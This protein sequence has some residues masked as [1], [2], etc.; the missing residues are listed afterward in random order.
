MDASNQSRLTSCLPNMNVY[1]QVVKKLSLKL[2][3][4]LNNSWNQE[5][6]MHKNVKGG[7]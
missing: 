1:R 3:N 4:N 5:I 6:A 2:N 7:E